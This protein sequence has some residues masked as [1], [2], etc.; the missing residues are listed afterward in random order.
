MLGPHGCVSRLLGLYPSW[1]LKMARL[2]GLSGWGSFSALD[3]PAVLFFGWAFLLLLLLCWAACSAVLVSLP[4]P[5][6]RPIG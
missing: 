3:G 1:F 4:G 5:S 2:T 6:L